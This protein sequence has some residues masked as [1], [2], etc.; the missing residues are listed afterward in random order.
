MTIPP[1]RAARASPGGAPRPWGGPAGA[2]AI[3]PKRA[4]RA[5]P[6]GA[7]RPWGGPAGAASLEI[8]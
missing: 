3:P 5:S 4:A 8:A 2:G 7:P 1:K 6:R